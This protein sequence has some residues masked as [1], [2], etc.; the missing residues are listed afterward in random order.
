MNGKGMGPVK[1]YNHQKY[2]QNYDRI[3]KEA[4]GKAKYSKGGKARVVHGKHQPA[5]KRPN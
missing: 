1:G 3:F 4:D 5:S 2:R